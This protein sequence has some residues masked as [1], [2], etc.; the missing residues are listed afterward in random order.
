MSPPAGVK[1][2]W[3]KELVPPSRKPG[4]RFWNERTAETNKQTH[5]YI[6]TPA[7][8]KKA[9]RDAKEETKHLQNWKKYQ[10]KKRGKWWE[11][12]DSRV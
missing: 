8:E 4:Q 11:G 2:V 1:Q 6:T 7:Q 12:G 3:G 10:R 5:I 9:Q